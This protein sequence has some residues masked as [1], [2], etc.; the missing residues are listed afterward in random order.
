MLYVLTLRLEYPPQVLGVAATPDGA[1]QAV[2]R[3]QE[4]AQPAPH[5]VALLRIPEGA[6][7]SRAGHA[8]NA[9]HA[10]ADR[11]Q[12]DG[13]AP[14]CFVPAGLGSS[15]SGHAEHGVLAGVRVLN[16]VEEFLTQCAPLAGRQGK[17]LFGLTAAPVIQFLNNLPGSRQV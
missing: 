14:A 7:S 11:A 1:Y 3:Q 10:G 17:D 9:V 12:H 2:I 16:P 15:A 4:D 5:D 6:E 8:Q 13:A